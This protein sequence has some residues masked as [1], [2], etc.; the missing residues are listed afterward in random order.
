M[1]KIPELFVKR[2]IEEFGELVVFDRLVKL[3]RREAKKR[4][5]QNESLE[6]AL[7]LQGIFEEKKKLNPIQTLKLKKLVTA[8]LRIDETLGD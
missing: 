4:P 7:R 1:V 8:G 3:F 6:E 2:F 5:G